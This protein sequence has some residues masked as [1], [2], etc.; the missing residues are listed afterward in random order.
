MSV[1]LGHQEPIRFNL[2]V[3]GESGTGKTTFL[4]A[5]MRKYVPEHSIDIANL[6]SKTVAITKLGS[7]ELKSDC[8]ATILFQLFD[9]PGYGD[10]A[11]IS[12][13]QNA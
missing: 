8:K 13:D 2:M 3:V 6:N 7:F 9:S 12:F 11:S 1:S 5:L 4:H 10:F